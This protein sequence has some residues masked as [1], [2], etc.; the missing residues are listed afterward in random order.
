MSNCCHYE[1]PTFVD[2]NSLSDCLDQIKKAESDAH[3]WKVKANEAC[4]KANKPRCFPDI[5]TLT[6]NELECGQKAKACL[7]NS[8][9]NF[10]IDVP[11]NFLSLLDI[12]VQT[13]KRECQLRDVIKP[14]PLPLPGDPLYEEWRNGPLG[15]LATEHVGRFKKTVETAR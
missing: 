5:E 9:N 6:V 7:Q 14:R 10:D 1:C 4:D 2:S 15:Q 13:P 12:I 3:Q 8:G 11:K